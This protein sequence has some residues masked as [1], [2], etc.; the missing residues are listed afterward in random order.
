MLQFGLCTGSDRRKLEGGR[1]TAEPGEREVKI[2]ALLE[3]LCLRAA[4]Y[5]EAPGRRRLTP[6][7]INLVWV[8]GSRLAAQI[9]ER[10]AATKRVAPHSDTH[11]TSFGKLQALP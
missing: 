6:N 1:G 2:Q 10:V 11:H 9:P 4:L 5:L 8:L 7:N 3:R